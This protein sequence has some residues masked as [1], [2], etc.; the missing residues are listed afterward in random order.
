MWSGILIY[1]DIEKL[2]KVQKFALWL[3]VKQWDMDYTS[4]LSICNL[5]TTH[6]MSE[7]FYSLYYVQ[8]C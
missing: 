4:L 6:Y 2:E 3:C 7:V 5:P 1:R 8:D